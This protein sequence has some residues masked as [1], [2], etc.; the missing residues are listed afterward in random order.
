MKSLLAKLGL[1]D[2]NPGASTGADGWIADPAGTRLVSY[3]PTTGEPIASIV[4]ATPA[5][6]DTVVRRAVARAARS[7]GR[8]VE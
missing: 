2:V 7:L 4:E 1:E 5:T 6:Y 8:E 3:N